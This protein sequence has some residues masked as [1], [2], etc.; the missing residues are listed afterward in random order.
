MALE[1]PGLTPTSYYFN[2]GLSRT[3]CFSRS[4]QWLGS[5]ANAIAKILRSKGSYSG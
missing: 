3:G 2:G 5:L 4:D 1:K